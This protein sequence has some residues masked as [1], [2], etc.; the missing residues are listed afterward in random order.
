MT[1]SRLPIGAECFI[2]WKD[3]PEK[4]YGSVYISFGEYDEENDCDTHGR[5]DDTVFFYVENE[6]ELI[7][8]MIK[9][10]GEDFIVLSYE[11][12]YNP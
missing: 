7:E 4:D 2:S 9:N 8:K 5:P 11:L 1:D 12:D 10:N 3:N 6:Y